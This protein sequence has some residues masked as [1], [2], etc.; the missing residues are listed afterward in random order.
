MKHKLEISK[1]IFWIGVNDRETALFENYWPLDKGVAYSSYIVMGEK[2][3]IIDTVK[4]NKTTEFLDKVKMVIGD[5]KVDY[6]VVNHME[7]DHSSSMLALIDEYPNLKIVG[8]AKTFPFIEGFYGIKD[9]FYKVAEG[10]EIDLG[11]KKLK[12]FMTPMVHWPESMMTYDVDEKVLFTMDAFGT[13]GALD[14]GIF[15]DEIN[16]D[17]FEDEARRYYSNVVAKYS[18]M[19]RKTLK[20]LEGLDVSIIAPAHGPIWRENPQKIVD[21]YD[22]WSKYEAEPGAVIIYGSMY[23]NTAEMADYLSRVI[24]ENGIKEVKVYDASTTHPSYLLSEIWRY[25]AVAI[26][27]CA[28]NTK[29]FPPVDAL[30]RELSNVSL[31]DRYLSIFGNKAWSGGGVIGIKK[32]AEDLKWEVVGEPVEATYSPQPKE[33][34]ALKKMGEEIANKIK[35]SI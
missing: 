9:N 28:Y 4:F 13:F 30:L 16:F 8:N 6:L 3:A 24:A 26:G 2:I 20:K 29:I 21:L 18:P 15:D 22:K 5:R 35:A 12:F 33:F 11:G 17:H 27:S 32:F 14:G 7:P 31:K 34:D 1:N 23:G 19:V 25:K 10:E